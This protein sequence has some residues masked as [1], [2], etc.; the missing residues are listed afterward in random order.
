MRKRLSQINENNFDEIA[1][2]V[3]KFQSGHN[4]VYARFL[5][6][7]GI[8]ISKISSLNEIPFL[9]IR[10]FKSFEVKSGEW[11]SEKV[12][13]SSGT[14]ATGYSVHHIR[15]LNFYL[16]HSANCYENIFGPLSQTHFFAVLP[17]YTERNDA[18]L[19]AMAAYFIERTQSALSGFY[20]G[21]G[22]RLSL[23]HI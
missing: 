4:P 18:S 8:D 3:F 1:L 11:Q 15:N 7:S 20:L 12:F 14:T 16:G 9:P 5:S 2:E 6:L 21:D 10:F 13:R 22:D 17:S 23:I 19:A